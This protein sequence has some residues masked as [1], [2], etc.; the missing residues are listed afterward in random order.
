MVSVDNQDF[1]LLFAAKLHVPE[2]N[3]QTGMVYINDKENRQ[4]LEIKSWP[5]SL[6]FGLF[7]KS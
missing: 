7:N 1:N 2:L 6:N 5:V 3:E 4:S